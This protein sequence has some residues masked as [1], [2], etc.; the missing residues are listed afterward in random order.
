MAFHTDLM[1]GLV[2]NESTDLCRAGPR[3]ISG[4]RRWTPIAAACLALIAATRWPLVP[5]RHLYHI[6][7]VNFARA[8]AISIPRCTS[9]NRPAIPGPSR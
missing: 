9:R 7:D 5:T 1:E 2:A 8:W 4:W 6:D 3:E